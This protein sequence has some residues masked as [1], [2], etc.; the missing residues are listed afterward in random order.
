MP[1]DLHAVAAELNRR[2]AEMGEEPVHPGR[3]I[4]HVDALRAGAQRD[5]PTPF[6]L[7]RTKR[8][9]AMGG[10]YVLPGT[11]ALGSVAE[12]VERVLREFREAEA[13]VAAGGCWRPHPVAATCSS[14]DPRIHLGYEGMRT[15][16][17]V[18]P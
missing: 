5:Q 9:V 2:M 17:E 1:L 4:A 12:A 13:R 14:C 18:K 3:A 6:L 16:D 10:Q 15:T 11:T 8:S 7:A